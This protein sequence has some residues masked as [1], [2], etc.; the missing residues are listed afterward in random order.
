MGALEGAMAG[1]NADAMTLFGRALLLARRSGSPPSGCSRR[2]RGGAPSSQP[3]IALA[4]AAEQ[5][6]DYAAA[7]DALLDHQV[8]SI[9]DEPRR[10]AAEDARLAKLSLRLKDPSG[11]VK[12]LPRGGGGRT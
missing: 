4:D 1:D 9:D 8:I 5:S 6:G 12:S 11:A 2:P 10:V 7:R 3:C